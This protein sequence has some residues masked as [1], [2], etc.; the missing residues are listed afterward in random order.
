MSRISPPDGS[1]FHARPGRLF[2]PAWATAA[3][4][5]CIFLAVPDGARAKGPT[6]D[7]DLRAIEKAFGA[8]GCRETGFVQTYIPNGFA[9]GRGQ[10]GRLVLRPPEKIRFE[11]AEPKGRLFALS[12]STVAIVD[13]ASKTVTKRKIAAEEKARY[14]LFDLAA[15]R[16]P[17]GFRLER[18]MVEG[19]LRLEATPIEPKDE[20][21]WGAVFLSKDRKSVRRLEW[22]D[23]EGNL[24]RFDLAD[25][26]PLAD[27]SD[28]LFS[29]ATP[30]GFRANDERTGARR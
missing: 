12:G 5:I 25:L 6:I 1:A 16:R 10:S 15:G 9:T 27:C 20:I 7:D 22:K 8:N 30:G 17:A 28:A 23:A 21:A 14:P 3:A 2:A 18:N 13:P 19:D 4:L 24:N 26:R 29:P 11:Y